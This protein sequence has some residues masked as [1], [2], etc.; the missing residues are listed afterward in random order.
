M[1]RVSSPTSEE[2]ARKLMY[3]KGF[4]YALTLPDLDVDRSEI[5]AQIKAHHFDLIVY[6]ITHYDDGLYFLNT[7]MSE[8]SKHQVIFVDGSDYGAP[9]TDE[10]FSRP[11]L[12]EPCLVLGAGA[13]A[14]CTFTIL[15]LGLLAC[16]HSKGEH[17]RRLQQHHHPPAH[18]S[19]GPAN[20][21]VLGWLPAA[22]RLHVEWPSLKDGHALAT[23]PQYYSQSGEDKH[24]HTHYFHNMVEGT[25]LEM[26]A[27]D[28]VTFSNT[29]FFHDSLG[30]R[31]VL[32][33]P[34]PRLHDKLKDNRPNDV[35]FN[36]AVCSTPS[37][38]HFI[39]GQSAENPVFGAAVGGILE[40]M[41]AD[42][43]AL[44]HPNADPS[45]LPAVMCL[46]LTALLQKAGATHIDF[47]SLD[48][49]GAELEEEVYGEQ[50]SALAGKLF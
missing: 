41:S 37:P 29:K 26:G 9:A 14:A 27:L 2:E 7:V 48:V 19:L 25:Y 5:E 10:L 49:E 43:R 38:V 1:Y 4:S 17:L 28:G 30:W 32:I 24:A 22:S 20:S 39:E 45:Q 36:A 46:G 12:G 16:G 8:Y 31:G 42:Y 18:D 15:M 35:C 50:L 23:E 44:W 33:E 40:F 3:G 6:G 47:F 13:M 34:N 21:A 11:D